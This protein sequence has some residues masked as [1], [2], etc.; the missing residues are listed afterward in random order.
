MESLVG[1]IG[2]AHDMSFWE[3]NRQGETFVNKNNFLILGGIS[4]TVEVE[5]GKK[6]QP[7]A[8]CSYCKIV[9]PRCVRTDKT[10]E[11]SVVLSNS[12]N[13]RASK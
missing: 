5:R 13:E 2:R 4:G 11:E 7:S 10:I 9:R 12:D 8:L 1:I 3:R 6:E